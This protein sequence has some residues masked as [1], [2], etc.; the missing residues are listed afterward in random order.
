MKKLSSSRLIQ[1]CF[2]DID[3]LAVALNTRRNLQL[4]QLSTQKFRADLVLVTFDEVLFSFAK[5]SC[6]VYNLGEK[7][8]DY[9]DFSCVLEPDDHQAGIVSHNQKLSRG[10]LFGFDSSRGIKLVVPANLKFCTVQIRRDIFQDCLEAMERPDI[11][12]RFLMTNHILIPATLPVIQAYLA[13]LLKLSQKQAELLNLPQLKQLI[14]E[15][16]VPLLISTIP[17]CSQ[18]LA[19]PLRPMR[20]AALVQRLE[21]Y[22]LANLDQPLTLKDLCRSVNTSSRSIFYGFQAIFG[23]S[24]M[25]YL[26]VQRLHGVRR[27]LQV[28]DPEA[29][30]ITAISNQFGFWSAG[31]FA[32]D[33]KKMFGELPSQTKLQS[34]VPHIKGVEP[35]IR[36]WS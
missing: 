31:H 2:T 26:K 15:D 30:N 17:P 11:D 18:K 5:A 36:Q 3:H 27:R 14:L 10:H 13:E 8:K 35:R 23:M 22:M 1:C 25:A 33:Y 7:A 16:F 32:R 4:T 34:R 12:Q 28:A 21:D 20:H 24:P 6:P 19:K 29:S 9:L